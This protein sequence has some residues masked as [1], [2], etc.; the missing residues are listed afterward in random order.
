MRIRL[1][2]DIHSKYSG[3]LNLIKEAEY[4]IQLGD[5][6]FNYDILESVDSNKHRVILG[7][8]ETVYT[9]SYG[10]LIKPCNHI[11]DNFGTINLK[12]LDNN[13]KIP[14]I[15]YSR[16]EHSI[17]KAWRTEGKDWFKDEELSYYKMLEA[18]KLYNSIKPQIVISHGCPSSMIPYIA[19]PA[20]EHMNIKP[21]ATSIMLE[22]M[23][24]IHQPDFWFHAHY[25]FNKC[26]KP[27]HT[28]FFCIDELHHID[29]VDTEYGYDVK[30]GYFD[31]EMK[32]VD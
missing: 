19:N 31:L 28:Y 12:L 14:D 3:Y 20:F 26:Y 16:G 4:S 11:L 23:Y 8:H 21:S 7:N 1:L 5:F 18:V 15:F 24:R 13:T 17:D 25:H 10:E 27:D 22:E 29:L 2:G 9:D 6:G 30:S 32:N